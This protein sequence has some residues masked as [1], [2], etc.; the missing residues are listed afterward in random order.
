MDC[1]T[2]PGGAHGRP[3]DHYPVL[4]PNRVIELVAKD[5][6]VITATRE[7]GRRRSAMAILPLCRWLATRLTFRMMVDL[8]LPVYTSLA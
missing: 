4:R 2:A 7:R 1:G 3:Q 8:W 6:A 5:P